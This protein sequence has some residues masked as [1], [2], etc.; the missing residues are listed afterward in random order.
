LTLALTAP[1]LRT[2]HRGRR[3]VS[4]FLFE[5]PGT[6][7]SDD[8]STKWSGLFLRSSLSIQ[9]REMTTWGDVVGSGRI[10]DRPGRPSPRY[11]WLF[12]LEKMRPDER[13]CGALKP[14]KDRPV[15]NLNYSCLL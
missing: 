6:A 3:S 12:V 14:L 13:G 8:L 10:A 2:L 1:L 11:H 7:A 4:I 5:D 9:S 15:A